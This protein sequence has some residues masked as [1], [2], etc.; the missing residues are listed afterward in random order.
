MPISVTTPSTAIPLDVSDADDHLR[1]L[2]ADDST[3]LVRLIRAAAAYIENDLGIAL[4]DTVY[5]ETFACWDD[6]GKFRLGRAPLD[7]LTSVKYY[8]TDEAEQTWTNTNYI[9]TG[10]PE[11]E[12]A[13]D[14]TLPSV[15]TRQYP[16]SVQ[17][18]AG[19]GTATTDIPL[20]AQQAMRM[21]VEDWDRFRGNWIT[22]TIS[23]PVG[24]TVRRLLA[25]LDV[26]VL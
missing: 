1:G 7:T 15:S 10:V 17:Y 25:Q 20:V 19:Y 18:T 13:A 23:V 12:I 16:W 21:I 9:T 11:I 2:Y 3:H 6:W 8:D 4:L 22:G 14:V 5:N 26:G 24:V